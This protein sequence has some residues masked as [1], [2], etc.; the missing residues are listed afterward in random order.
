PAFAGTQIG[1]EITVLSGATSGTFAGV[2][3]GGTVVVG[4]HKYTVSYNSGGDVVLA[5]AGL[6]NAETSVTQGG[7]VLTVTDVNGD[8][9]DNLTI[10]YDAGS[11][12][13]VIVDA[14]LAVSTDIA[15]ATQNGTNEVRV[16]AAGITE[17]VI[18]SGE[19]DDTL[20][21]DYTGATLA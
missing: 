6:E 4:G 21:L 8:S 3:E 12:E 9:A 5:Y 10:S 2:A 11:A 14:L 20:T 16:S 15:G 7:S 19:G 18:N 17:I 13:F 1:D